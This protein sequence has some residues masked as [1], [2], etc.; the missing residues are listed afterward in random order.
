MESTPTVRSVSA[1]VRQRRAR[2]IAWGCCFMRPGIV[3]RR[4]DRLC[5][6]R[7]AQ[8]DRARP[9]R[10]TTESCRIITRQSARGAEPL[11]VFVAL[12]PIVGGLIVV[13]LVLRFA[14]EPRPRRS[15]VMDSIFYDR[16]NI[17]GVVASSSRSPRRCRSAL[18]RGRPRGTDHPDRARSVRPSLARSA[19]DLQKS[20]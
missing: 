9:Q 8:P 11:G 5:G 17:R 14:P 13:F 19:V 20:R 6:R 10:S 18:A 3:G 2:S 12:S 16:G 1:T 15:E 7:A 4:G